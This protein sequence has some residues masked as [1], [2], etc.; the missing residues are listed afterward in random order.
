MGFDLSL[1]YLSRLDEI[2]KRYKM[3]ASQHFLF[4]CEIAAAGFILENRSADL[5]S[6]ELE[7]FVK[8]NSTITAK[9]VAMTAKEV[10]AL[11]KDRGVTPENARDYLD[12]RLK[13]IEESA[14]AEAVKRGVH[15][16]EHLPLFD[17]L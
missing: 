4:N 6:S 3:T 9:M 17:R 14:Q 8:S 7:S 12:R 11:L 1:E 10:L 16:R 2:N 13:E 15:S 5:D